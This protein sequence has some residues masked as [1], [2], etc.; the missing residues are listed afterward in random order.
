MMMGAR[1]T[2]AAPRQSRQQ[3][4]VVLLRLVW[5]WVWA[6]CLSVVEGGWLQNKGT[7]TK[8]WVVG[9]SGVTT[10]G[11]AR[12][13]YMA[14]DGDVHTDWDSAVD[15]HDQSCWLVLDLGTSVMLSSFAVTQ[16]GD[17]THD[18]K[19]H[20][21]Q[22]GESPTGPW[23]TAGSFVAKPCAPPSF[24]AADCATTP[25]AVTG[26]FRQ[27]FALP[28]AASG[29]YWRWVAK[30]RFTEYQVFLQE[31]ELQ[32][33]AGWGGPFLVVMASCAAL[34]LGGFSVY[35]WKARGLRGTAIF[36]HQDTWRAVFGLVLD[37]AVFSREWA[38]NQARHILASS[39]NIRWLISFRIL[40]VW[41][42]NVAQVQQ[43]RGR[44]TYAPVGDGVA[45][46]ESAS[47][48]ASA[49]AQ[50]TEDGHVVE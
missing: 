22:Y 2:Q 32:T 39:R 9:H 21:L 46:S 4:A 14:V 30:T 23:K 27:V 29:R 36:P 1:S 8:S 41:W 20:E 11:E 35:N 44:G 42:G 37:G 47:S 25:T 49:G 13:P 5:V 12:A 48:K 31:L 38:R 26:K 40:S 33:Y 50:A 15:P 7:A 6:G 43:L 34:Y 16:R 17:T 28:S 19:D 45:S 10:G 24:V 18:T 3:G